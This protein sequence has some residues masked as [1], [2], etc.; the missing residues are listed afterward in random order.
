MTQE[1]GDTASREQVI[2]DKRHRD[3]PQG[4]TETL[5]AGQGINQFKR[6]EVGRGQ[7]FLENAKLMEYLVCFES[8]KRFT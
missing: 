3:C 4:D 7:A 2:Q 1:I 6:E 5:G 8:I